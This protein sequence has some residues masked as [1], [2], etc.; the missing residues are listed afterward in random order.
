MNSVK[1]FARKL[2]RERPKAVT[3]TLIWLSYGLGM[4]ALMTVIG[5]AP[6]LMIPLLGIP[7]GAIGLAASCDSHSFGNTAKLNNRTI[8][9]AVEDVRRV[10]MMQRYIDKSTANL[11]HLE[12]L[13]EKLRGKLQTHIDDVKEA[14]GRLR[15]YDADMSP[16]TTFP[17]ARFHFDQRGER[18]GE[19]LA[20]LDAAAVAV[21]KAAPANTDVAWTPR[22]G[23][24]LSAEF[25]GTTNGWAPKSIS[26]ST[27][28]A[29]PVP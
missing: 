1:K 20:M 22:P 21:P 25:A 13:P 10:C 12:T 7:C 5:G 16:K 8:I 9:G 17:F 26:G 11:M 15:V 28:K 4:G 23:K 3:S 19:A 18:T 14:V 2:E 27:P 6:W 24:A 29:G